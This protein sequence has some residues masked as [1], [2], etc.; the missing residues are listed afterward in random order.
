MTAVVEVARE[1]EL[2]AVSREGEDQSRQVSPSGGGSYEA[3]SH[4]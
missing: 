3:F 1:V 2:E 4:A